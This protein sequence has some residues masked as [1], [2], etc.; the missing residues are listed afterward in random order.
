M[1]F[2]VKDLAMHVGMT[3]VEPSTCGTWTRTTSGMQET[4][5]I[6]AFGA[7]GQRGG[8]NLSTLKAQLRQAVAR[9]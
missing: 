3:A 7:D 6:S 2:K 8:R 4:C 1:S 9:A 5:G